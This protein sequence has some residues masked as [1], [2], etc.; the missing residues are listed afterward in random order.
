MVDLLT[1]PQFLLSL[2]AAFGVFITLFLVISPYLQGQD[3]KKRMDQ[4]ARQEDKLR[5]QSLQTS[6]TKTLRYTQAKGFVRNIVDRFDLKKALEAPKLKDQM[7]A[8]GL[9]GEG[10][11]YTYYFFRL[12]APVGLFFFSFI[13]LNLFNPFGYFSD[14]LNV[15]IGS[16]ALALLGYYLP[17][18][19]IKNL[20]QKRLTDIMQ[21]FP[22]ALDFLLICVESGMSIEVSL[23]LVAKRIAASSP[24]LAEEFMLTRA[25]LAYLQDRRKAYDNL[26]KRI[27]HPGVQGVVMALAQAERYGTPLGQALRTM[28]KENR[29][30][31]MMAAEKKAASLPA[32]LTVPMILFFLPVIFVVI[33][34]P[35]AIQVVETFSS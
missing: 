31:R 25:E 27:P 10:V 7:A 33:A 35:A 5:Q 2:L 14:L 28:A 11:V 32:K 34:T 8:A 15:L 30:M 1:Q 6:Q 3:T 16:M 20:A 26:S 19:Y 13:Y 24:N 23:D 29:T 18:L 9:R 22:D 17:G 21:S 4:I 12:F